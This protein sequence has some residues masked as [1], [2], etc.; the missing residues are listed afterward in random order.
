MIALSRFNLR[1]ATS[2]VAI[3]AAG[4]GFLAAQTVILPFTTAAL[5]LPRG[6][7]DSSEPVTPP[8]SNIAS[9]LATDLPFFRRG[10]I[11][12]RPHALYR[13]LRGT[14]IEVAPGERVDTT[15]NTFAP[16]VLVEAGEH[17]RV[18]YTPAWTWYSNHTFKNSVDHAADAAGAYMYDGWTFGLSAAYSSTHPVLV[19]TARQS[20]EVRYGGGVQASCRVGPKTQLDLSLRETIREVSALTNAP[21]WAPSNARDWSSTDA[22]RF[23]ISTRVSLS[24]GLTFGYTDPTAGPSMTFI[25]PEIRVIWAPTEL[26]SLKGEAGVEKR[27]FHNSNARDLDSPVYSAGLRYRPFTATTVLVDV[28]REVSVSYLADIVTRSH[29]WRAGIEQRLIE[30]L[31]FSSSFSRRDA[32]YLVTQ[33]ALPSFRDDRYDLFDVRLAAPIFRR[34]SVAVFYQRSKNTSTLAGYTFVSRQYGVE[35][36]FR[37]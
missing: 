2:L 8:L 14:G 37:F 11:A 10:P 5:P 6:L 27:R 19:E 21:E 3:L 33:S 24:T 29:G 13:V 12:L 9:A 4:T 20:H 35:I 17:W 25:R 30:L 34:G 15:T 22:L 7:A 23:Q 32:S 36:G 16:G 31:Y 28:S 26:I 18:D 1:I